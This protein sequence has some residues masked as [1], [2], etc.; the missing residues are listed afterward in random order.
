MQPHEEKVK[1][2]LNLARPRTVKEL[3]TFLGMVTYF[4]AYI[5]H[6]AWIVSPLFKLLKKGAA[7]NWNDVHNEAFEV[8]KR[9]LVNAP[10][11]AYGIPGLSYRLYSD[12]SAYGVAAILQQVQPIKVRELINTRTYDKLKK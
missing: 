6:F 1:A 10:V 3:Q 2:I 5:P 12:A 8:C 9:V 4:S 11:R 7:W